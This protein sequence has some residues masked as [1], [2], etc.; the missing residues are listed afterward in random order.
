MKIKIDKKRFL[1]FLC[2]MGLIMTAAGIPGPAWGADKSPLD[3]LSAPPIIV[4]ENTNGGSVLI[5]LRNN[6]KDAVDV[7]LGVPDFKSQ[8]T[9][10][11]LGCTIGFSDP[12]AADSKSVYTRTMNPNQTISFKIT[13]SGLWEAGESTA[14]LF[15]NGTDRI[16]TLKAVKYKVP[17]SV[18]IV[19]P[20]A[21]NSVLNFQYGREAVI[22]LKNNDAMTYPVQ[23]EL[24]INGNRYQGSEVIINPQSNAT[25]TFIPPKHWFN[26]RVNA[27]FK[28]NAA[29]NGVLTLKFVPKG[30]MSLPY[31]PQSSIPV[32]AQLSYWSETSRQ[33]VSFMI[34]FI[35]LA[36]GGICSFILN[37]WIPNQRRRLD[38]LERLNTLANRIHEISSRIDST[39]RVLVRV[40][41]HRL[42]NALFTRKIISPDI[43][44]LFDQVGKGIDTL[45][46]RVEF[47]EEIDGVYDSMNDPV[48]SASAP[49]SLMESIEIN[50]KKATE[51]LKKTEP[52]EVDFTQVRNLIDDG[53]K[54]VGIITVPDIAF[55]TE[56]TDGIAS[57]NT[58]FNETNGAIGSKDLCKQIRQAL[59]G[60][61]EILK[62][63][64]SD[65]GK[66]ERDDCYNIDFNIIRLHLIKEFVALFYEVPVAERE[67][68]VT[69]HLEDL[70]NSLGKLN[71]SELSEA[72]LLVQQ[73]KEGIFK[74]D[75][76]NAII[77]K[78]ISI[79]NDQS[80]V[81]T[82]Q[83]VQFYTYFGT[84]AL[85]HASAQRE[86]ELMWDFGHHNLKEDGWKVAHYF[87]TELE[88]PVK[89]TFIDSK[90]NKLTD[91]NGTPIQLER[92][93]PVL[94]DPKLKLKQRFQIEALRFSI[95][96]LAA[97]F[98]LLAGAQEQI[99][100][101]DLI[102]GLIA[103][104]MLGF[105][106]DSIKNLLTQQ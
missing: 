100:K 73:I 9:G 84:P 17:F 23:W 33:I 56:L 60:P 58:I 44:D 42:R 54:L 49:P 90:G 52:Q 3:L 7:S 27:L 59:P 38:L 6:S 1:Y 48:L 19:P 32:S 66:L 18:V 76:K 77:S 5:Q 81:Y 61:F 13:V 40:E 74:E 79:E 28:T 72:Q 94:P 43:K 39:L 95:A 12:D 67:K 88:Y 14:E 63:D 50:L 104:F 47:L 71:R 87:P 55:K 62:E 97:L 29:A 15:N 2:A 35:L 98:G 16:G 68:R 46:K 82:N 11:D 65:P 102:P 20:S 8:T 70:L 4:A 101:L 22:T 53:K 99:L 106:A 37:S 34:I 64:Y 45:F 105:T 24:F 86:F 103:V 25:L 75:I 30:S 51:L 85:N 89:V 78:T 31:W 10:R 41:R 93:I 92:N 96:F 80:V 36:L 91:A 69:N 21:D 26:A 83:A 57:L